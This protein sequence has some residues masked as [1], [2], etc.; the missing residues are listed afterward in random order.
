MNAKPDIIVIGGGIIGLASAWQLVRHGL[1]VTLLEAARRTGLK[2][3]RA[4]AGILMPLYPWQH[5]A[6]MQRQL[7]HSLRL[8]PQLISDL[9]A[10][11]G[12][13]AGY[14]RTGMLVLDLEESEKAL[15]WARMYGQRVL[16]LDS[17]QCKR[18]QPHIHA[19][20]GALLLPDVYTV[21]NPALLRCMGRRL[22]QLGTNIICGAKVERLCHDG[23]SISSVAT[24][25]GTYSADNYV[26]ATGAW[27]GRIQGLNLKV[28]PVRGQMLAI[29]SKPNP[30]QHIILERGYYLVPRRGWTLVGSTMEEVG[31]DNGI[32]SDAKDKLM[33]AAVKMMPRLANGHCSAQWS[34][35]RPGGEKIFAG[36]ELYQN[37]YL[38]TGH[39]RNGL[40]LALGSAE[41]LGNCILRRQP[42]T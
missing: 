8:Y 3:S 41:L 28:R 6:N 32:S 14:H 37:L 4:G 27:S 10:N 11:T 19:P 15:A 26:L 22:K 36:N 35:L 17:H 24:S 39:Y 18:Q 16:Q 30:L 34:G 29:R 23:K 31:F 7:Q 38:N 5:D 33:A 9:V 12:C 40:A 25:S 2:A 20:N 21:D 1:K 42:T 13:D